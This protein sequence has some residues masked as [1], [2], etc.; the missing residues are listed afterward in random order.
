[1][2]VF[3]MPSLGADMEDGTL[4]EWTV[5]E[6]DMIKRGDVVAVIET[7]KGAIEIECFE[8]GPISEMLANVGE[9]V[10]V[11]AP[12]AVIGGPFDVQG[13]DPTPPEIP[14]TQEP[15]PPAS[16]SP[17]VPAQMS[18]DVTAEGPS[19][20]PAPRP[21]DRPDLP[22][23]RSP[24]DHGKDTKASPAARARAAE[25]GLDLTTI[26]GTGP[27]GVIVLGDLAR[28]TDNAMQPD[29][30]LLQ[31]P[32]NP[33]A[34]MR[35]A[36]AAA[37]VR[38]KQTIPHFYLT[39]SIDIQSVVDTLTHFNTDHVPA[40]RLLLGA[41]LLH[42]TARAARDCPTLNGHFGSDGFVPVSEVHLGLAIALRGGGLVAP[43]V[44][45]ADHLSLTETMHAMRDLVSRARAGRLRGRETTAGTLTLT[46]LGETGPEAMAGIIYPPQVALVG[47]GA[48]QI[49]PWVV[50][51]SVV[52]RKTL[53]LT[54]S[55]DHRV[56]DGRQAAAFMS[57]FEAHLTALEI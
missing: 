28:T 55:A 18:D 32:P 43:A 24:M 42:A 6:G 22:Q 20:T 1:M 45:H 4:I 34:E 27:D 16:A 17:E 38:S 50:A 23:E 33:K 46:S 51:G 25:I 21:P 10:S 54:L 57:A 53:T 13:A 36:I 3:T 47:V 39:H 14:S 29:R 2:G 44:L 9:V 56:N 31:D 8:D 15:Q 26:T 7:Q 52:P 11:G 41:V 35:K 5:R 49:R 48:P 19:K 12:M 40:D 37:M 30:P